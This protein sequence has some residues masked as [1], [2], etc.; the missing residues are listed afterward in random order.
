MHLQKKD[1]KF[2]CVLLVIVLVLWGL[3]GPK[4]VPSLLIGLVLVAIVVQIEIYRRLGRT[5]QESSQ[6]Q[7]RAQ[8]DSYRQVEALF[9]VFNL[10]KLDAPM[11]PM[12]DWAISPDFAVLIMTAVR[13]R[14]PK[15]VLELGSG[16]ST[17]VTAYLLRQIGDGKV[18]S[19]EHDQRF[20][21]VTESNLKK[22]GLTEFSKVICSPVKEI[23]IH[24]R[25]NLY[26]CKKWRGIRLCQF[27]GGICQEMP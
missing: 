12:R 11:P 3:F 6:V 20:A 4:A 10:L 18:I 27:F 26:I 24:G 13:E 8:N 21:R 1:K 16:V 14:C 25:K 2:L 9:S 17:L 15:I 19:M 22:H 7:L 23:V 5:L